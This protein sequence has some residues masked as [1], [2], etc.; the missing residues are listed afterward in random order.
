M[1]RPLPT[2]FDFAGIN[3]ESNGQPEPRAPAHPS[4]APPIP[5]QSIRALVPL[6]PQAISTGPRGPVPGRAGRQIATFC[7]GEGKHVQR[8]PSIPDGYSS[9]GP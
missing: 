4:T 5:K 3:L 8:A 7:T 9:V 6:T 1:Y 2:K